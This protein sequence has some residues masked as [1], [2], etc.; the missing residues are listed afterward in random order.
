M[1]HH[2]RPARAALAVVVALALASCA[3]S[4]DTADDAGG[5]T[6]AAGATSTT[7]G[8]TTAETA[9]TATATTDAPT[10]T[11]GASSTVAASDGASSTT[12]PDDGGGSEATIVVESLDDIP[13]ECQDLLAEFLRVAEPTVSAVDWTNATFG[14]FQRVSEELATGFESLDADEQA[15]GC[16]AY[17]FAE[18][19]ASLAAAIELAEREAPGTVPWLEFLGSLADEPSTAD[20]LPQDCDGALAYID[21]IVADGS[22]LGDVPFSEI[23][24]ITEVINVITTE[25]DPDTV[26]EF[27]ERPEISDFLG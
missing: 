24:E 1:L 2:R 15:A 26:A 13:Q 4:D 19:D 12:A 16:D 3:D 11:S 21:A 6:A 8:A 27:L 18:D 9:T 5:T 10:A 14:D 22:T 20:D 7:T 23:D 17:D 25:C